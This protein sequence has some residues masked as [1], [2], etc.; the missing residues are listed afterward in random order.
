MRGV[1]DNGVFWKGIGIVQSGASSVRT[2][3]TVGWNS[4][5][6]SRR[7]QR[8]SG[9]VWLW[10]LAAF[11][12]G[13][14]RA[15]M[16]LLH[17]FAIRVVLS[18]LA[19][20]ASR[21]AIAQPRCPGDFNGDRQVTVDEIISSVNRALHGCPVRFVD[22]ADGSINDN[23][24]GLMWEKKVKFDQTQDL[25]NP[26]DA[27][28]L[29]PWAGTCS[30]TGKLCQPTGAAATACAAGAEGDP[31]GCAQCTEADGTCD[32]TTTA[33]TWL[34]A[35]N[36]ANLGTHSDW[37]LPKRSELESIIDLTRSLP[38][39]DVAFHGTNCGAAC[40]DI[41]SAACAC[42]TGTYWSSTT[43]Q[44]APSAAWEVTFTDG[45]VGSDVKSQSLSDVNVSFYVRA[46][47]GL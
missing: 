44:P 10:T 7:P 46:V 47:R 34:V 37:R 41:T 18:A 5:L 26:Q 42:T 35:L 43:V 2:D 25:A 33:W 29:Y 31:T 36:A 22:N 40:A 32:A 16:S 30:A 14:K 19:V 23:W 6:R 21:G 12:W 24:T 38:A 4:S 15:S 1:S 17:R 3:V 20:M 27:D 39:V 8:H 45:Q 11:G 28:N 13:G 9:K